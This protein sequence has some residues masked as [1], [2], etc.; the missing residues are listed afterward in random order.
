MQTPSSKS[1]QSGNGFIARLRNS[2]PN[3]IFLVALRRAVRL[4]GLY[5][6]KDDWFPDEFRKLE[7][8]GLVR[9]EVELEAGEPA[10]CVYPTQRAIELVAA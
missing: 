2:A 4:G 9:V 8:E 6:S 7:K 3:N 10:H 5:Y 1:S